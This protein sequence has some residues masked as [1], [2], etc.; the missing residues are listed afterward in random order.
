MF[1]TFRN[2]FTTA[3]LATAV[4]GC[5]ASGANKTESE[6]TE[7][8]SSDVIVNIETTE[9]NIKAVLFGDTPKHRDNFIKLAKDGFY[10]GVQIGRAHV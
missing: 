8:D 9:G 2:M 6:M 3:L 1:K 7:K 4:T 5:G 10:N